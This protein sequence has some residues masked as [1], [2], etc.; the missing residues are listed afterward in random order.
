MKISVVRMGKENKLTENKHERVQFNGSVYSVV[1][2][3]LGHE[4]ESKRRN[5]QNN[6]MSDN[7]CV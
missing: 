5:S 2:T 7:P 4:S 3:M 1:F 6:T